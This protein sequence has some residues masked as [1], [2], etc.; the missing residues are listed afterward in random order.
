MRA[1]PALDSQPDRNDWLGLRDG[2]L[3]V[4]VRQT[5]PLTKNFTPFHFHHAIYASAKN[6]DNV[7]ISRT[8]GWPSIAIREGKM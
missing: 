4:N 7:E 8:A 3:I 2:D 1:D 6:R 5:M